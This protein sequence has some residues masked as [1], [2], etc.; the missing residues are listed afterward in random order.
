MRLLVL[1]AICCLGLGLAATPASALPPRFNVE[2]LCRDKASLWDKN[3]PDASVLATCQAQQQSAYDVLK[4]SWDRYPATMREKCTSVALSPNASAGFGD[5]DMLL[6]CM[7]S[8]TKKAQD[9][10]QAAKFRFKE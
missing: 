10:D 6:D 3:A 9:A 2:G 4:P 8:E 7:Q 1:V 5:Y